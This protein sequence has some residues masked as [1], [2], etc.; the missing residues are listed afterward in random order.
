MELFIGLAMVAVIGI[1]P[2]VRWWWTNQDYRGFFGITPKIGTWE[3]REA[4]INRVMDEMVG[5]HDKLD[6]ERQEIER[7]IY[8]ADADGQIALI[9][10]LQ[11][12]LREL[13]DAKSDIR[14]AC[15]LV[16]RREGL[17]RA[18]E[19]LSPHDQWMKPVKLQRL[20][21]LSQTA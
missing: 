5:E 2:I 3:A 20:E 8:H 19:L 4:I 11:A 14:D 9:K 18:K 15:V 6:R 21:R 1:V 10:D 12:K 7:M 17:E 13:R 16:Q